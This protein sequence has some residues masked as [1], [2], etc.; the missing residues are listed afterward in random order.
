MRGPYGKDRV[1]TLIWRWQERLGLTRWQV[2]WRWGKDCHLSGEPHLDPE[3]R[4]MVARAVA[5]ICAQH[6]LAVLSFDPRQAGAWEDFRHMVVHELVHLLIEPIVR[7]VRSLQHSG[8]VSEHLNEL[9]EENFRVAIEVEVEH[10]A[11]LV[12][13]LWNDD[14]LKPKRRSR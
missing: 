10:L 9:F 3:S 12:V 8:A 1:S 13:K 4:E 6:D 5:E 14:D 11:A 7:V 2:S